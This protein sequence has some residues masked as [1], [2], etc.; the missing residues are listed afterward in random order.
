MEVQETIGHLVT[1]FTHLGH[2]FL[3]TIGRSDLLLGRY[4]DYG[5]IVGL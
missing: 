4:V 3:I 5:N 2:F 1:Q